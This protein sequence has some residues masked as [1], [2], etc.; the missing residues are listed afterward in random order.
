MK[1]GQNYIQLTGKRRMMTLLFPPFYK[2]TSRVH[3]QR[4][5][6]ALKELM[7]IKLR[8]QHSTVYAE[9]TYQPKQFCRAREGFP[10]P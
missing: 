9:A 4:I 6:A 8:A 10:I 1:S 2:G 7:A 5:I 3:A